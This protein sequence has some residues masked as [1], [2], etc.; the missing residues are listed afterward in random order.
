MLAWLISISVG[1]LKP[2][3]SSESFKNVQHVVFSVCFFF[4]TLIVCFVYVF[5]IEQK[6]RVRKQLLHFRKQ[7]VDRQ[8]KK[9]ISFRRKWKLKYMRLIFVS[10]LMCSMPWALQKLYEGITHRHAGKDV[11]FVVLV[12]YVLNL[13][14]LSAVCV[15]IRSKCRN[16][17]VAPTNEATQ[18][19][20]LDMWNGT[21]SGNSITENQNSNFRL[22]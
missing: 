4:V 3:T 20:L 19:T 6:H 12:V 7:L 5:V 11:S 1:I 16:R 9:S 13:Y 10:Y 22:P 8:H 21:G 14:F 17:R 2:A 18:G 15:Y